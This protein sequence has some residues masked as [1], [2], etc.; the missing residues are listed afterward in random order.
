MVHIAPDTVK[1]FKKL[2][3]DEYEANYDDKEAW[4]ATHNLLGVFEWL[5]KEDA[6]QNP[7]NYTKEKI[8]TFSN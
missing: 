7:D 3:N 1:R 6:K 2:F 5:L 4:E 8:K